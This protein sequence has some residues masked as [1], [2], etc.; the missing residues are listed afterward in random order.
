[1]RQINTSSQKNETVSGIFIS[2]DLKKKQKDSFKDGSFRNRMR[3]RKL[4]FDNFCRF[5]ERR[6]RRCPEILA[7]Y[8]STNQHTSILLAIS[9]TAI[10]YG[11]LLVRK[12]HLGLS[13]TFRILIFLILLQLNFIIFAISSAVFCS[14]T[15]TLDV[16]PY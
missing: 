6:H 7:S 11:Y 4:I 9:R 2:L 16:F 5:G 14:H 1:M 3:P 12:H 8:F 13:S 10:K 15:F